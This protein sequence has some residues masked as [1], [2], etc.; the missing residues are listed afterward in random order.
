MLTQSPGVADARRAAPTRGQ[1][2]PGTQP[3][4]GQ[5]MRGKGVRDVNTGSVGHQFINFKLNLPRDLTPRQRE[6]FERFVATLDSSTA[7]GHA[8][9]HASDGH[10]SSDGHTTSGRAGAAP[11]PRSGQAPDADE[12]PDADRSTKSG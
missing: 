10:A 3:G 11:G 2:K 12:A 1:V 8:G 5:R 6:A 9:G 4:D 7:S